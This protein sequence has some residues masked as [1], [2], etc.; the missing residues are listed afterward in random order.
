MIDEGQPVMREYVGGIAD[1]IVRLGAS[2]V[3]AQIGCDH[4]KPATGNL[5]RVAEAD[6][7]G[8]GVGEETMEE[9]HGTAFA[10]L[11]P[12]ELGAVGRGEA[13]L[14]RGACQPC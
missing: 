9:Q 8:V 12:D 10:Q 13:V 2:A 1:G 7:V 5:R 3:R 11:I 14:N 4:P 6:P